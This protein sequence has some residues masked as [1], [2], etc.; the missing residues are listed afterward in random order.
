MY[1]YG[2]ETIGARRIH[3]NSLSSSK[4][5]PNHPTQSQ[6][7][8]KCPW[9]GFK[10][11]WRHCATVISSLSERCQFNAFVSNSPFNVFEMV[12]VRTI[13]VYCHI[14][15][16]GKGWWL[17]CSMQLISSW[18]LKMFSGMYPPALR[19]Q[20]ADRYSWR[21]VC[22]VAMMCEGHLVSNPQQSKLSMS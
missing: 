6:E 2:H 14:C 9:L 15:R 4:S 11:K 22:H 20:R 10:A 13:V 17:K 5:D 16:L 7:A 18:A 19:P 12:A 8:C 1:M 21:T 3:E